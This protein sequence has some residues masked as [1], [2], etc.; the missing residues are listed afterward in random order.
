MGEIILY[1]TLFY[2]R[3]TEKWY[4]FRNQSKDKASRRLA[5]RNISYFS[6]RISMF[7][8]L[9]FLLINANKSL[10]SYLRDQPGDICLTGKLTRK[11]DVIF[12]ALQGTNKQWYIS[13][14]FF[15]LAIQNVFETILI[16][17]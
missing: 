6:L 10:Y 13:F 15:F 12:T 9:C 8:R 1:F 5:Y 7:R 4:D 2:G 3:N 17:S 11:Y 16:R 14:C